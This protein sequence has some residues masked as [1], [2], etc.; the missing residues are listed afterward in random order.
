MNAQKGFTLIELMI[1]VAIIGILAAIAI[2]QY[3]NYVTKS[4]WSA[5]L[6][7]ISSL[8]T[9]IGLCMQENAGNGTL[10]DTA[11]ELGL[12]ALP[13]PQ[14]A[15]GAATLTGTAATTGNNAAPGKVNIAFTGAANA[16]SFVY[17]ADCTQDT[18][19][20]NLACTATSND[21]IPTKLLSGTGR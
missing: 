1:V 17:N 2:P 14:Y 10:C 6:S 16:G 15:T 9:A 12:D 8:K 20:N 21:T 7:S 18:G 11:A 3:Q 19:G 4:R 5:N 13:T